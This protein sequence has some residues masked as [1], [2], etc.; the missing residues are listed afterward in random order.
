MMLHVYSQAQKSE[1]A[2]KDT[3]NLCDKIDKDFMQR[4]MACHLLQ[5]TH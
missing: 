4:L 1:D 3:G 2:V 5:N